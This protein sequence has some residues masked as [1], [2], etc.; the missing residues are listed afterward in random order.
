MSENDAA[1]IVRIGCASGFADD[2]SDAGMPIVRE[3]ARHSGPRFLIYETL[4]ERT[5]ALAQLRRRQDPEAGASEAIDRFLRPVLADCLEAGIRIVGNFG[6]ANPR[7]GARAIA[8]LCAELGLAKIRI[9]VV[10]G[11]DISPVFTDAELAA[12]EMDGSLLA[13]RREI[14]SANA[15]IGAHE[16][17]QGLDAGADIVVTGRVADP[18]LAL[19]P[20][21]HAFGWRFDDWD[22]L[23]AGTLVGHLLECGSQVTGGYF[24]DPGAKDVADL[25]EVGYPIA[26][27]TADGMITLTKPPQTGGRVDRQTVTEQ[28]L[29]EIH[30]PAAYLTPDVVLDITGVD[31]EEVGENRVRVSG[32]RGHPRP[33]RLKATVCVDGGHLAEGEIS[34]AGV[35]APRRALL[36]IELVRTRMARRYPE[37]VVRAD[38]IGVTSLF[39]T[40]GSPALGAM[41]DASSGED[42]RVRLSAA[43]PD[44]RGPEELLHEVRALYCAGPAGGAGIRT[45]LTHRVASASCL[46]ERDRLEPRMHLW[47]N[48]YG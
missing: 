17:A 43:S 6:A 1:P 35:N 13:G 16:I 11:D 38:A 47:S 7:A 26:E 46:V 19:G 30:D 44:R 10:E 21:A 24:A 28:L 8:R 3:L 42:V 39:N 34:Y 14:V 40:T 37:L 5:L 25:A 12:C 31:V 4:A 45:R 9:A 20:L 2:R 41:L 15:Y 33:D 29:Y 23:A 48:D 22:R 36:A 18:S 32:A 27:V